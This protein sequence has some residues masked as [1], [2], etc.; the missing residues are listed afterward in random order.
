MTT[1][2]QTLTTPTGTYGLAVE[3]WSKGEIYAVAANWSQASA[4]VYFYE[5]TG[6][7]QRQYQV[8]DFGHSPTAALATEIAEAIGVSEGGPAPDTDSDEVQ[9]IVSE[10][11]EIGDTATDSD[12]E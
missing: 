11:V 3:P 7:E 10:A 6:W 9:D 2:I 1:N 12:E 8:A 4:P 5:R